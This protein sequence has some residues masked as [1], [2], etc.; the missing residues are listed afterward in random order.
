MAL[1]DD[2]K[3]LAEIFPDGRF[4]GFVRINRP[5]D[6]GHSRDVFLGSYG[7]WLGTMRSWRKGRSEPLPYPI[8]PEPGGLLPWGEAGRGK[9]F[10]LTTAQDP[11]VWP[12][13][14]V[15]DDFTHWERF[16]ET[17][18]EF[19]LQV[20]TARLD[21]RKFGVKLTGQ[22]VFRA[23][24]RRP[25]APEPDRPRSGFWP[26][27]MMGSSSRIKPV[28]EFATLYDLL[29]PGSAGIT[30]TDWESVESR[31]GLRLPS[32]YKKFVDNYGPGTFCD[33]VIAA[34]DAPEAVDLF[35]LLDRKYQQV[36]DLDRNAFDVPVYPEP[37]GMIA[38]GETRDGW[39]CLWAP[40]PPDDPDAWGIVVATPSSPKL[41]SL[42]YSSQLS[43]SSLLCKHSEP[44]FPTETFAGREPWPGGAVFTPYQNSV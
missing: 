34:P 10:W 38:W 40:H 19:L 23:F 25:S 22:P 36:R 15:D 29:G 18:C 13:I 30:P 24:D 14:V 17:M 27:M 20:V 1:P 3:Q 26:Q 41:N 21:A 11:G 32:D 35:R 6:H 2:Y 43:F 4:R 8:Y 12:V 33:V 37:D 39:T 16:D 44:E 5:G 7:Y 31:L 42:Q 28:D 9:A